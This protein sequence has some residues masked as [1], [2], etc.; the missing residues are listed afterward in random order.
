MAIGTAP[1]NVQNIAWLAKGDALF[2]Y[3]GWEIFRQSPWSIPLGLNPNYG[4]EFGSSIVYSDSIPLLAIFFK[5]FSAVLPEPFQYFGLWLLICFVLQAIYSYKL[6]GLISNNKYLRMFISIIFL[7][8]PIMFFRTNIHLALVGHFVLLWALYLNLNKRVS[9]YSW[10]AILLITLGIHFYLFVMVFALWM[11][12]LL[13]AALNKRLSRQKSLMQVLLAIVVVVIGAWQYGYMA[14]A[15]SSSSGAGYGG[16]QFNLLAFFNPLEWSWLISKNIFIPPTIEGFAY[17]GIGAIGALVLGFVQLHKKE[18]RSKVVKNIK[19]H[20]ALLFATCF[21]LFIAVSN[22]LHIGNS[23]YSFP[24]S[25]QFLFALNVVRASARLSWPLQYLIIFSAI[26]AIINGYRKSFVSSILLLLACL[27][28]LDTYNGWGKLHSYFQGLS[29]VKIEHSLTHEFWKEAPKQYSTIKLL[30][31]QNWPDGWNT[32]AA[33]AAENKM[34]TNSVFLARFDMNKVQDAKTAS[35]LDI[36]SG[37]LDPKT[38][39]VFQKWSDNLFQVSPKIDPSRDLFARI[40][41]VNLLAPDYK[42]CKLCNPID[43][44]LEISTLAPAIQINE[45]VQFT[46][47]GKGE[48]LLIRGW[49]W[50]EQWGTWSSGVKSSM[51]IPLGG[52]SIGHLQLKLRA[53]V[54]PQHPISKVAIYIN[55]EYQET[56]ELNKQLDNQ[57]TIPIPSKWRG[58]KFILLEFRYLNPTSPKGA[59]FG[60]QDERMLTIGLESL[61][62]LP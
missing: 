40:D 38:I 48:E 14:I 22:N 7:F 2:N 61:K 43:S 46:K 9:W 36:V 49:S 25:D 39:Y 1:L 56:V 42:L 32:F 13:D 37:N 60:N 26:W 17:M 15:V 57:L 21:M 62:L 23:H 33:Y 51:A 11:A 58:E 18:I 20:Q 41:G 16:D 27:Q 53:L 47:N 12:G 30:P 45:N 5:L 59:G 24:I 34:A 19:M 10:P 54:S 8:S 29:G 6:G 31:P 4:L 35:D 55:G 3:V 50:P 52:N 28:I 44:K